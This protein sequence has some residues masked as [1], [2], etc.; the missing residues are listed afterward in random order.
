M[1]EFT[2]REN[3]RGRFHLEGFGASCG[4]DD[5]DEPFFFVVRAR[6]GREIARSSTTT[7]RALGIAEHGRKDYD[8]DVF[9]QTDFFIARA[10]SG[11]TPGSAIARRVT[12]QYRN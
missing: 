8:V 7:A 2:I 4:G 9:H 10:G 1:R 3:A 5:R 6:N 11:P 12:W